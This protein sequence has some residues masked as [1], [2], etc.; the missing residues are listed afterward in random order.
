M[1]I[2]DKFKKKTG[3]PVKAVKK[4]DS[5]RA[6]FAAV[7]STAPSS[8][9]GAAKT[10]KSV[11]SGVHGFGD[12]DRVLQGA[13]ITE[14]STMLRGSGQYVFEVGTGINKAM[15]RRCFSVYYG[16]IPK[17]VRI[18]S[19]PGKVVRFGKTRGV[20]KRRKK[21]IVTLPKGMT[22]EI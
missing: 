21:V 3:S 1:S 2:F 7:G 11:K 9:T 10:S 4:S 5:D 15:V 17:Q 8:E 16:V 18:V 14:K 6:K 22:I 20:T 19:L 12:I 13:V